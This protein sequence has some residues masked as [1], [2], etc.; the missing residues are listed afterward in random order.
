MGIYSQPCLNHKV[1]GQR[2]GL[3]NI[4]SAMWKSVRNMMKHGVLDE[5]EFVIKTNPYWLQYNNFTIIFFL[6][7]CFCWLT[8]SF[9]HFSPLD[10]KSKDPLHWP[11][12]YCL[13]K[14]V[15][16]P[17]TRFSREAKMSKCGQNAVNIHAWAC[18]G[19]DSS[20][21]QHSA[22][23]AKELAAVRA[24]TV[25]CSETLQSQGIMAHACARGKAGEWVTCEN[26]I[27]VK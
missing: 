8:S 3:R 6:K 12:I 5:A 14:I 25:T 20:W 19:F 26:S 11:N 4:V 2:E 1:T 23:S 21:Y 10:T 27:S 17:L 15:Y 22:T 24:A 7:N 16:V 13:K 18:A 9:I